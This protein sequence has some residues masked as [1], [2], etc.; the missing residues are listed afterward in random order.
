MLAALIIIVV[1]A[2]VF[3]IYAEN[4]NDSKTDL[5][6][7]GAQE[8]ADLSKLVKY[9]PPVSVT[10]EDDLKKLTKASDSFKSFLKNDLKIINNEFKVPGCKE[11]VKI[12]VIKIYKDTFALG[13]VTQCETGSNHVWKKENEKWSKV[14]A[15]SISEGQWSCSGVERYMIPRI[16]IRECQLDDGAK[17]TNPY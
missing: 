1:G 12:D 17:I 16:I 13:K 10:H 3:Y 4:K 9:T 15:G 2:I 6:V 7:E 11:A 8:P 5:Y 14:L